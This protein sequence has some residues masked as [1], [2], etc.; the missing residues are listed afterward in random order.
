LNLKANS[1]NHATDSRS[2]LL[3]FFV[4]HGM[5]PG[6]R[7]ASRT[8]ARHDKFVPSQNILNAKHLL[9]VLPS[10]HVQ[11]RGFLRAASLLATA[12]LLP[13]AA[14]STDVSRTRAIR[15]IALEAGAQSD[16]V[17]R[18]YLPAFMN[19]LGQDVFIENHGGAGGRI[20]ARL[21]AQAAP[22]GLTVGIGGANNLVLA[23]L[24]ERDAGYDPATDF[25]YLCA[26]ARIPFA[27]AVRGALDVHDLPQLVAAA[28][29]QPGALNFGT[30]GAGGSSHLAVAAIAQHFGVEM[31]HVPF[32]S[33]ALATQE[34]VAGRIDVVATDLAR[35]LPLAR[36]DRV[37]IIGV[38]GARRSGAAPSIPTLAEQGFTGFHIDPWYGAYGPKQM[39]PAVVRRLV[40]AF[41]S[42]H[43]DAEV[44]KRAEAAGL[45][46]LPPNRETLNALVAD[47]LR[48]YSALL[49]RLDLRK[50][51]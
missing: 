15:L 29:R 49:A 47:D 37:R 45:E 50:N 44:R 24:L 48:R 26:L 46:L 41:A 7:C 25:T 42:A 17:A 38:T 20:A 3:V 36:T 21:V 19:V 8:L 11:R 22:N 34:M 35:L 9:V 31:L 16:S 4:V 28:R 43:N 39:D 10:F 5:V 33:S 13:R 2:R 32:R 51:Q 1:Q 27:V 14:F 6:N 30:A 23:S 40:D 18:T 12:S